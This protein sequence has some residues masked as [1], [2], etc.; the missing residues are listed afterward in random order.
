MLPN[1]QHAEIDSDKIRGYLLSTAHPVGRFKARFFAALGFSS[2]RWQ[3]LAD[4][5]RIQH[6]THNAQVARTTALGTTYTIRAILAGP[7]GESAIVVSVW[8]LP[9]GVEAPR[10]VTAYPGGSK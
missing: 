7:G 10:F 8:F 4:A 5:L 1:A 6:L 9:I 3:E 2:D